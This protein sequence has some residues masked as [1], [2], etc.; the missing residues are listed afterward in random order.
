MGPND[1]SGVVWALGVFF[2]LF[3]FIYFTLIAIYSNY[4]ICTNCQHDKEEE[5]EEGRG[6]RWGSKRVV[7][8]PRYVFF[9]FFFCLLSLIYR[10]TT[11]LHVQN[12]NGSHNDGNEWPPRPP[13]QRDEEEE[14]PEEEGG[15]RGQAWDTFFASRASGMFFSVSYIYFTNDYLNYSYYKFTL[16]T[17]RNRDP[18]FK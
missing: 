11:R 4:E 10:S 7:S 14:E 15:G 13:P 17:R 12:G 18:W 9:W 3:Y 5:E 6:T 1:A 2:F 8:S 16:M